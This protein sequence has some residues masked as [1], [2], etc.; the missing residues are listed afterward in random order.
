[1]SAT[2]RR[3]GPGPVNANFEL[4]ALTPPLPA[5]E[6]GAA[7]VGLEPPE[8]AVVV[9]CGGALVVVV[10]LVVVVL[11]GVVLVVVVVDVYVKLMLWLAELP[12]ASTT[13]ISHVPPALTWSAVGGHG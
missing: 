4:E 3:F 6:V 11:V 12:L 8:E 1:M 9:V 13:T 5:A 2:H 10:E 7:V